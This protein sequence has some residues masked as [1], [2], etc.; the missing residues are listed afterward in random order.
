MS[1]YIRPFSRGKGRQIIGEEHLAPEFIHELA[2]NERVILEPG[3]NQDEFSDDQFERRAREKVQTPGAAGGIAIIPAKQG[4]WSGNNSLGMER[5]FAPDD[6]NRQTILKL[7]EWDFPEVWDVHLGIVNDDESEELQSFGVVAEIVAGVGGAVQQFEMDWLV[8]SGFS[9]SFNALTVVARYDFASISG[10]PAVPDNLR[11]VVTIGKKSAPCCRAQRTL[12]IDTD[13]GT[14]QRISSIV[15][16]PRFTRRVRLLNGGTTTPFYEDTVGTLVFQGSLNPAAP[17]IHRLGFGDAYDFSTGDGI[18]IA[19]RT[20]FVQILG[21]PG[22]DTDL[23]CILIC[24]L[25]L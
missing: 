10:A 12:V 18:P 9:M 13:T 11:L 8:G 15:A 1:R 14:E 23:N 24:E 19:E 17:S 20:R 16:L 25:G 7:D 4:P 22:V 6:N 21:E 5:A 3:Y 2:E